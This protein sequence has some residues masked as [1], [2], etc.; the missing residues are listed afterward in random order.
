MSA[1]VVKVDWCN[2][3][4]LLKPCD[5]EARCL[6]SDDLG[7]CC[8]GPLSNFF[9]ILCAEPHV[10]SCVSSDPECSRYTQK[11]STQ[12]QSSWLQTLTDVLH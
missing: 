7:P 4:Q 12:L 5:W 3:S 8:S 1:C 6:F 11:A 2:D 9:L 10:G